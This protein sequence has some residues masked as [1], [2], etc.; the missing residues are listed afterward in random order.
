MTYGNTASR[1]QHKNI[2]KKGY[3]KEEQSHRK[4]TRGST[5][6]NGVPVSLVIKGQ[7]RNKIHERRTTSHITDEQM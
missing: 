1:S 2:F 7:Y 4:A 5:T 3:D 6:T